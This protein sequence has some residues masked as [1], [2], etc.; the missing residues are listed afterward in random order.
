MFN[1][2]TILEKMNR[3]LK[4]AHCLHCVGVFF[5]AFLCFYEPVGY[6]STGVIFSILALVT[7]F[8]VSRFYFKSEKQLN[9]STTVS[10]K[11]ITRVY[12]ERLVP[13]F[14]PYI[15]CAAV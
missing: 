12:S 15:F 3:V 8:F 6:K 10:P 11:S 9:Q 14:F 5:I 1:Q 2:A 13:F 4:I 7:S